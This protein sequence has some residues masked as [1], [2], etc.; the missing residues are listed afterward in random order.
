MWVLPLLTRKTRQLPTQ[1]ANPD[2]VVCVL[3]DAVVVVCVPTA[4][5]VVVGVLTDA[6]VVVGVLTDAC[7]RRRPNGRLSS[8]ASG[9]VCVLT[10]AA[11]VCVLAD[12]VV[13]CVL[14]DAVVVVVCVLTDAI[15][16]VGVLTDACRRRRPNGR[17]S[18]S[19][20]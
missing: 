6:V 8:S 17:L 11:V 12:A 18:S 5:V 16:V 2:P 15:V 3:T 7:R 14:T 4:A 19:A 1:A 20:S 10:D 9:V 13:A